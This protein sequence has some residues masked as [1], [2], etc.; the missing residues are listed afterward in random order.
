MTIIILV[1]LGHAIS[2]SELLSLFV[3]KDETFLGPTQESMGLFGGKR[4][5]PAHGKYGISCIPSI[6]K[7]RQIT[8]TDSPVRY[9][10]FESI[11]YYI[12]IDIFQN[13]LVDIDIDIDIFQNHHMTQCRI[14]GKFEYTRG[15]IFKVVLEC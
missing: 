1:F 13:C 14:L 9:A 8:I 3:I 6:Q 10:K 4:Y 12:D 2:K 5:V 11:R 7:L 15:P